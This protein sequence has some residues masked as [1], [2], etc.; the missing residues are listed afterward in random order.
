MKKILLLLFMSVACATY[1]QDKYNYVS[2]NK[3]KEVE[4]TGFVIA[5]VENWGKMEGLKSRFLLFIDTITGDTNQVDFSKDGY[6]EKI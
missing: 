6:F 4:G 5:T 3:L 1:G 2:F